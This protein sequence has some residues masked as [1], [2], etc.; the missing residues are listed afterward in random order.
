MSDVVVNEWRRYGEDRLYVNDAVTRAKVA[1]FDRLTGRLRVFDEEREQEIFK[2][3]RP[4]LAGSLPISVAQQLLLGTAPDHDLTE[5][6][7]GA[8]VAARAREV[9]PQGFQRVAARLFR[10][11]TEA[12]SWEVG[13]KGER[14][15]GKR[16]A[17]LK[18]DGWGVLS[19]VQLRSGADIDHIVIGPPGV[20]TINTKHHREAR[21]R[22]GDHV[23]WVNNSEQRHYLRNSQHEAQ[24]AA[25][26]LSRACGKPVEVKPMLAFVGVAE[27]EVIS[28][29]AGV[30][31]S[32]GEDIDR[33]LRSMPGVLTSR[34]REHLL[35]VARDAALWLA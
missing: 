17:K 11:P 1:V 8:A 24:S 29:G 2:A 31:I 7:P 33:F 18:R 4:F 32:R 15:V 35:T 5:N 30:L 22:V 28:T 25:R 20:F 6:Q 3:L 13:A 12:T 21:I 14:I 10:L 23:V 16:L 34:E 19:S 9:G 27:L 26:R